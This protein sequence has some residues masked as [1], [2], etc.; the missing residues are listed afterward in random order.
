MVIRRMGCAWF[1]AVALL[2][3]PCAGAQQGVI[4]FTGRLVTPAAPLPTS[5]VHQLQD[6]NAAIT[7]KQPLN[8]ALAGGHAP[9][10][11]AYFAGYA[12][13]DTQLTVTTYE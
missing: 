9:E 7:Y 3:S 5:G 6:G 2:L 10:L 1:A 4:H 11:L 12:K 13:S 8:T